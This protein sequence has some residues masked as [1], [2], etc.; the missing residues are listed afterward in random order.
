MRSKSVF[1]IFVVSALSLVS[2]SLTAV[3]ATATC[4]SIR[5]TYALGLAKSSYINR[6]LPLLAKPKISSALYKKYRLLDLDQ[7]G[8]VC[9]VTRQLNQIERL[10]SVVQ[11]HKL[12][13][14]YYLE[15]QTRAGAKRKTRQLPMSIYLAEQFG[16]SVEASQKRSELDAA[17]RQVELSTSKMA[18]LDEM[19]A[20]LPEYP[21]A[22]SFSR[23]GYRSK[24][25][26]STV[27]KKYPHGVAIPNFYQIHALQKGYPLVSSILYEKFRGL[28]SDEDGIACEINRSMTRNEVLTKQLKVFEAEEARIYSTVKMVDLQSSLVEM[29]RDYQMHIQYNDTGDSLDELIEEIRFSQRW[30]NRQSWIMTEFDHLIPELPAR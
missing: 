6:G 21:S 24:V 7:D 28:D 25:N 2:V 10:D 5:S 29:Q 23:E 4:K 16:N 15:A 1:T 19:I 22:Q 8:I 20:A 9:E 11:L 3:A 30:Q 27:R 14:A 17:I 12:E 18:A 26:C 13:K